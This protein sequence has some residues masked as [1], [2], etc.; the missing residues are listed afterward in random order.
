MGAHFRFIT[1]FKTLEKKKLW[2][3]KRKGRKIRRRFQLIDNNYEA[4]HING[5]RALTWSEEE[6]IKDSRFR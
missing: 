5:Q 6:E 1:F 4:R 3:E 2:N